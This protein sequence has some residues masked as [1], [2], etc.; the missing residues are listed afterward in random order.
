M[1]SKTAALPNRSFGRMKVSVLLV[2]GTIGWWRDHPLHALPL[3]PALLLLMLTLA[4][5]LYTLF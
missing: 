1:E 4:P 5:F 3:A 2:F